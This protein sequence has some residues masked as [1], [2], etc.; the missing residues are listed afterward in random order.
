M[1][2]SARGTDIPIG[3][4]LTSFNFTLI[5]VV[6]YDRT[7]LRLPSAALEHAKIAVIYFGAF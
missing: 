2:G 3:T 4:F 6:N 7:T 1:R 5:A